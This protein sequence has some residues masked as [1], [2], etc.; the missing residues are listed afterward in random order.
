M[1]QL[2]ALTCAFACFAAPA[3]ASIAQ[4]ARE[5][6][7]AIRFSDRTFADA[8]AAYTNEIQHAAGSDGDALSIPWTVFGRFENFE[9]YADDWLTLDYTPPVAD[10]YYSP[11]TFAYRVAFTPGSAP[12][13]TVY[14]NYETPT[15]P[16]NLLYQQSFLSTR[17]I[18]T[19]G[20]SR[21]VLDFRGGGAGGVD[22]SGVF[23]TR[24]SVPGF[25]NRGSTEEGGALVSWNTS[26]FD[27]VSLWEYN[28]LTDITTLSLQTLNYRGIDPD[29]RI[30]LFG[31]PAPAPAAGAL[32][33]LAGCLAGK[34]RRAA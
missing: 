20:E 30:T 3:S 8:R 25:W 19:Y 18:N 15:T 34:R 31:V 2:L 33:V 10:E 29:I 6:H 11:Q 14:L 26:D 16:Q 28:P 21:W 7:T 23:R 27:A 22:A 12:L 32:A 9:L 17:A 4:T 13:G 24:V 5:T 1:R